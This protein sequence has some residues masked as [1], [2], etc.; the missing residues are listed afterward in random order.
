MALKITGAS[1]F[2]EPE[3]AIID[4]HNIRIVAQSSISYGQALGVEALYDLHCLLSVLGP[5]TKCCATAGL[6]SRKRQL[7]H[8]WSR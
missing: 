6:H 7:C 1:A 5:T 3:R 2:Q 8:E 4:L